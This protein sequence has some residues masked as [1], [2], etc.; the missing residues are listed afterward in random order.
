MMK[1]VITFETSVSFYEATRLT[2]PEDSHL[3]IRRCED[4]KSHGM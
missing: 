1:A 3:H 4:L 2:I